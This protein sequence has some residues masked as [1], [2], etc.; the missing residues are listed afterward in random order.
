MIEKDEGHTKINT[1]RI[2][3]LFEADLNFTLSLVF[4]QRM[5]QFVGKHCSR[6][7]SQYGSMAGKVCQSAVLNK[8]L[9]FELSSL[10]KQGTAGMEVDAEGCYDRMIPALVVVACRRL[11]LPRKP[12]WM[13]L[14]CMVSMKH[15]VRTTV[16]ESNET[17][18]STSENILY[19]TGQG[20][21]GS[22]SC[23]TATAD[24]ILS[25]MSKNHQGYYVENLTKTKFY[26]R[27]KDIFVDDASLLT[28]ED[29]DST[30]ITK[31]KNNA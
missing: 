31:L 29:A 6:H 17:Y 11:G 16:G 25:A 21:G 3:Q 5:M 24:I 15:R 2:I 22:P 7:N 1:V 13:L 18:S 19:G 27:L 9:S 8:I 30:T 20:S 26:H 12:G 28:K 14:D 10:L 23:W 4:G